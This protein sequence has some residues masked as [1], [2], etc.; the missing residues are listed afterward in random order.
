I[1]VL[2]SMKSLKRTPQALA[3]MIRQPLTKVKEI[4]QTLCE[5]GF[6]KEVKGQ[7]EGSD[8]SFEVP[9]E[10]GHL[11]IQS[12]HRNSLRLAIDAI[13]LDPQQRFFQSVFFALDEEQYLDLCEKINDY[14]NQLLGNYTNSN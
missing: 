6:A 10:L 12:F 4:L 1:H 11:G 3:Q 5:G 7:W 8:S 2:V 9:S 13:D 14:T